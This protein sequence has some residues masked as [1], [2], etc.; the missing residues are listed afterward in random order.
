[1]LKR[2]GGKRSCLGGRDRW[3]GGERGGMIG[4]RLALR[5]QGGRGGRAKRRRTINQPNQA[6]KPPSFEESCSSARAGKGKDKGRSTMG[7]RTDREGERGQERRGEESRLRIFSWLTRWYRTGIHKRSHFPRC[8]RCD[9]RALPWNNA[10][11]TP[12]PSLPLQGRTLHK[13]NQSQRE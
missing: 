4:G 1:M 3:G 5:S 10:S 9:A 13:L 8:S 11:L 7:Q 2:H 6:G 12:H